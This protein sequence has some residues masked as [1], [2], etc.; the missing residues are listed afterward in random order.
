MILGGFLALPGGV[1][2]YW[3]C[4]VMSFQLV[5]GD[6]DGWYT[7]LRGDFVKVS[8]LSF[9]LAFP[10]LNCFEGDFP[11]WLLDMGTFSLLRILF[12]R[13]DCVLW[14]GSLDAMGVEFM[15]EPWRRRE[16]RGV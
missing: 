6:T 1:E 10:R 9:N 5:V 11:S 7:L 13:G 14:L 15:V 8:S 3:E 4:G 12:S 2:S 16:R